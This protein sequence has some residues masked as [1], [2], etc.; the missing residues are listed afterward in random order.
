MHV[1]K[2]TY[3][4]VKVGFNTF[5]LMLLNRKKKKKKEF[6]S[7]VNGFSSMNRFKIYFSY[8]KFLKFLFIFKL[9][10]VLGKV[11][12]RYII[13]LLKLYR[14]L[15]SIEMFKDMWVFFLYFFREIFH[16]YI[17]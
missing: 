14:S 9:Q 10:N 11:Q 7:F 4:S 6:Y 2:I 12:I 1:H 17:N 13:L 5:T 15:L 16:R 3:L 8:I